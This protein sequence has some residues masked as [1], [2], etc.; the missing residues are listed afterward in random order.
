MAGAT[1]QLVCQSRVSVRRGSAELST[2]P[3]AAGLPCAPSE[4]RRRPLPAE[5]RQ[6]RSFQLST[7]AAAAAAA[8]AAA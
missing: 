8:S 5:L 6:Q 1:G 2:E 4:G 7:A 3:R